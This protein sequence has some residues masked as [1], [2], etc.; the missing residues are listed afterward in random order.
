MKNT[1][2]FVW[3]KYMLVYLSLDTILSSKLTVSLELRSRHT[4]CISEQAMSQCQASKWGNTKYKENCRKQHA[5]L[6]PPRLVE[7]SW[8][9]RTFDFW[10]DVWLRDICYYHAV[11]LMYHA[12][13]RKFFFLHFC[14]YHCYLCAY[15]W[16]LCENWIIA[17]L[18][19]HWISRLSMRKLL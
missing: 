16:P 4:V 5:A 1:V 10:R 17:I 18:V 2:A 3:H 7:T 15:K 8:T 12:G 11:S 9:T 14:G 6:Y 19:F 13:P